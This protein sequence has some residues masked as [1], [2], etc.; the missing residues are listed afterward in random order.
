MK[1]VISQGRIKNP[2]IL[3]KTKEWHDE[4][5]FPLFASTIQPPRAVSFGF[6]QR[7]PKSQC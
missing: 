5:A 2:K 6:I 3:E 1:K 7:S 4:M